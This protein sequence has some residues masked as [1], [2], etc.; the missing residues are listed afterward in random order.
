VLAKVDGDDYHTEWV[1][2]TVNLTVITPEDYEIQSVTTLAFAGAGVSVDR[3]DEVTTV[4]ISGGSGNVDLGKFKIDIGGGAAFLATT[5]DAD[6]WGGYNISINPSNEGSAYINIP[7]NANAELG[8]SLTISSLD[9][10]SSVEINTDWADPWI[11]GADGK[12][13][14][15]G[16]VYGQFFTLRGANDPDAEIGS[17]GYGGNVVTVYGFEGFNVNTGE[18]EGGLQWQFGTD[19]NLTLPQTA[20]RGITF[21]DGTFQ[22]TA[23]K[24]PDNLMLDGGAA[25]TIYEV[26]VDYA[27]GGF[28][29]T[30]Y[31]VNTPSFNGGGAEATE[32][33]QYTLDGGGA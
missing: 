10:N 25:A 17:L 32:L 31:G 11:F 26:T 15:P 12:L 27:E 4:T 20:G 23:Y 13:T 29:S 28:S 9:S 22:K 16:E 14:A 3:I 21:G 24:R 5:D 30:R 18:P 6:G 8:E 19:G 33:V 2:Q 1:D 7:N